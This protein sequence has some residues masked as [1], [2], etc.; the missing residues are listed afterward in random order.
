MIHLDVTTLRFHK[1][2]ERNIYDLTF[3]SAIFDKSGK[4]VAGEQKEAH[5]DLSDAACKN[6]SLTG[7]DIKANFP[8]KAG[9][10]RVREVVMDFDEQRVSAQSREVEAP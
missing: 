3:A 5:L 8:L 2:D 10:Y 1:D 4:Y 6:F 7:L 9:S